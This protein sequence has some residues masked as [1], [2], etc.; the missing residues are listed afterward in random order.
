MD[1]FPSNSQSA[2]KTKPPVEEKIV[3]Q[4]VTSGVS[5]RK[6]PLG[7]RFKDTFLSGA[8][9]RSVGQYVFL[10]ILVPRLKDMVVDAVTQAARRA[11][12]G[13]NAARGGGYNYSSGPAVVRTTRY[14]GYSSSAPPAWSQ[15]RGGPQQRQIEPRQRVTHQFEGI[16][17]EERGD[18]EVVHEKLYE[19]LEE[20]RVVTVS[21]LYQLVGITPAPLD[22]K[23]G[24]TSLSGS[25]ITATGGSYLIDLPK[26]SPLD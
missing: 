26:P 2:R 11:I 16:A 1:E 24:W 4:I 6:K 7:T 19:M 13:E 21:D 3:E 15:S 23:W 18:A 20:Y 5:Q 17:L 10:D 14:D 25:R 9:S 22:N 12:L 8:D